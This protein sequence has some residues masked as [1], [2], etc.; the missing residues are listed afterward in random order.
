LLIERELPL[1]NDFKVFSSIPMPPA[2][3][4]LFVPVRPERPRPESVRLSQPGG[5]TVEIPFGADVR[6]IRRLIEEVLKP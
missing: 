4:P 6:W 2:C 5:L 3:G 1:N